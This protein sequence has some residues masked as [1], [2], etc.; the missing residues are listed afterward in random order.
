MNPSWPRTW[1]SLPLRLMPQTRTPSSPPA[2]MR[3]QAPWRPPT[4]PRPTASPASAT[5]TAWP[6][7]RGWTRLRRRQQAG[8]QTKAT[9]AAL[10]P[11]ERETLFRERAAAVEHRI[12]D[13]TRREQEIVRER[14]ALDVEVQAADQQVATVAA[15][16]AEM[17]ARVSAARATLVAIQGTCGETSA[18]TH[19]EAERQREQELRAA[20]AERTRAAEA[21]HARVA[22]AQEA[23]T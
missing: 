1:G 11:A 9:T 8:A 7:L 14:A 18:K 6:R 15:D 3:P 20:L 10:S 21:V 13:L 2:S 22:G 19:V 23:L 5:V 17:P 16:L 4:R 12:T